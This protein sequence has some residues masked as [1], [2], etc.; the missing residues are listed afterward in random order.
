M[1]IKEH[2]WELMIMIKNL[3]ST[4][5]VKLYSKHFTLSYKPKKI[6]KKLLIII[7]MIINVHAVC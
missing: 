1:T 7:I 5:T 6:P 2:L 3:Y 4:A